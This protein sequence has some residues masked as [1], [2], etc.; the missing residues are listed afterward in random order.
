MKLKCFFCNRKVSR[1][2][3]FHKKCYKKNITKEISEIKEIAKEEK[4]WLIAS[5]LQGLE[6]K[7][8]GL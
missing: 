4:N 1:G 3:V 7:L 8:N 2:F 6:N 5:K